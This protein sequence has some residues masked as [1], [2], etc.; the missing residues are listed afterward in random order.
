MKLSELAHSLSDAGIRLN[1][2]RDYALRDL[3]R[4]ARNL[5]EKCFEPTRFKPGDTIRMPHYETS[6]GFRVWKVVGVH[7]GGQ[8]QE[9]TYELITLDA[10]ENEKIHVPCIMLELHPLIQRM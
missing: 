7:L 1:D 9:G 10:L 5:I 2:S 4:E 8:D 6:G 3:L